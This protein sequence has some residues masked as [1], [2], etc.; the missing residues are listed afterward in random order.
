MSHRS[1]IAAC[2]VLAARAALALD[3]TPPI[4]DPVLQQRYLAMTHELRCM[5]CQNESLADSQVALA[6]DL[7]REVHELILAGKTDEQIREHFVARYGEFI[8]LRP[9]MNGRNA[10]LWSAPIVLLLIGAVVAIRVIRRRAP[11]LDSD[12]APIDGEPPPR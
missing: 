12:T 10:W 7:R 6:A 1:L 5:Q 3:A 2:L 4:P 9:R 11:L 8:L